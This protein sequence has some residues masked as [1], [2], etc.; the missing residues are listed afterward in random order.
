M[1][2][3]SVAEKLHHSKTMEPYD[4]PDKIVKSRI[5]IDLF[6][7]VEHLVEHS[8]VLT[9]NWSLVKTHGNHTHY[10][11]RYELQ[12]GKSGKFTERS[13]EDALAMFVLKYGKK[14]IYYNGCGY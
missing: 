6:H 12:D 2:S 10:E 3:E 5:L 13:K 11:F 1:L 4:G 14:S 8:P 7:Y 9:K